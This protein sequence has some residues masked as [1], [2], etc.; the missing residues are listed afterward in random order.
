MRKIYLVCYDIANDKRLR[1]TFRKMNGYGDHLQYSIFQCELSE[2]EKIE[3]ITELT[4]IIHH[5]EDQILIFT[6]GTPEKYKNNDTVALGKPYEFNQ[7]RAV[8]I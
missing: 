2:K 5:K 7:R 6:L 1:Q 3:M 4:E 8:V